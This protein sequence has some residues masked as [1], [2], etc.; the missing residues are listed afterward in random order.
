MLERCYANEP[1][2]DGEIRNSVEFPQ[3]CPAE[4]VAEEVETSEGDEETRVGC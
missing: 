4:F 3:S 2:I 1:V